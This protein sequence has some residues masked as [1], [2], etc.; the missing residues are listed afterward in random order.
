[1]IL[2]FDN[3][4]LHLLILNIFN[5]F[6]KSTIF[7]H[8]TVDRIGLLCQFI[9]QQYIKDSLA[10]SVVVH[11]L[12]FMTIAVEDISITVSTRARSVLQSI[13]I[14]S[15]KVC[16]SSFLYV[17]FFSLLFLLYLLTIIFLSFVSHTFY[18]SISQIL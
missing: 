6:S 15:L 8:I 16:L 2:F 3:L 10:R 18:D 7:F 1:M 9:D 17:Y 5:N 12:S 11:C 13:K 4:V 14:S